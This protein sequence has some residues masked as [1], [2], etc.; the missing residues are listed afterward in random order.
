M[1]TYGGIE[2]GLEADDGL[3][4]VK[5]AGTI[6]AGRFSYVV[7]QAGTEHGPYEG[8]AES[9]PLALADLIDLG[10]RVEPA[11]D[12]AVLF[13]EADQ[14]QGTGRASLAEGWDDELRVGT[15]IASEHWLLWSAWAAWQVGDEPQVDGFTVIDG[16]DDG[17]AAVLELEDGIAL[18]P[19][20]STD[21]WIALCGLLPRTAEL[22]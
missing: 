16:G 17:L 19:C 14:L 18:E 20:T 15:P 12:A 1:S 5:V 22:G 8:S 11:E 13:V 6:E 21:V 4:V 3:G 7:D 10:P 9:L 2:F